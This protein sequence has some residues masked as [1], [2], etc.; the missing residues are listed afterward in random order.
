MMDI[1]IPTNKSMGLK[2]DLQKQLNGIE[3]KI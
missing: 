3:Y 1:A 2:I